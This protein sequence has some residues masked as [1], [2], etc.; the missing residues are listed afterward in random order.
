MDPFGLRDVDELVVE[1][2]VA[3]VVEVSF[4]LVDEIS[5]ALQRLRTAVP[6]WPC[7]GRHRNRR[8]PPRVAR[9]VPRSGVPARS[10][11]SASAVAQ[12]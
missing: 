2:R 12:M 6:G 4:H 11:T 3:R 7:P 1:D 10:H 8:T 9:N 5:R